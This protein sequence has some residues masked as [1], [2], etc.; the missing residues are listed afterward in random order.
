VP[1]PDDTPVTIRYG[2]LV[3]LH[4]VT[5][6]WL[7]EREGRPEYANVKESFERT[8]EASVKISMDHLFATTTEE[9]RKAAWDALPIAVRG[10]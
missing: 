8:M 6:W 3:R 7:F 5:A 2:D 10:T 4:A 9:Q 1:V